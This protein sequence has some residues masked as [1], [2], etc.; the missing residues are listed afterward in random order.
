MPLTCPVD[1][2]SDAFTRCPGQRSGPPGTLLGW[3]IK[4]TI[5]LTKGSEMGDGGQGRYASVNGLRMYFEE[6]G[7]EKPDSTAPPLVLLHDAL[8]AIEGSFGR[9]VPQLAV[10]RRVIAVEQQGHGRTADLD[11]PLSYP[12]M[13]EDTAA[14]LDRIRVT[15]ADLFGLGMGAALAVQIALDRP[16]LV[17]RLV[18]GSPA[19]SPDGFHPGVLDRGTAD[20][21]QAPQEYAELA[22][23]PAD[24]AKVVAKIGRLNTAFEGWEPDTI[25]SLRAPA[26]LLAGDAD[27]V[28]LDH[29][30][31]FFRL[32]GGG[33][34]GTGDAGNDAGRDVR[35]DDAAR[36]AASQ[37]AVLPGTT[38]DTLSRRAE[39]VASM[40]EEFLDA[41]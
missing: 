24:W 37:L 2:G 33:R 12:G 18:L 35:G 26:L 36:P 5:R 38:H 32:V 20:A 27:I 15:Q 8:S 11:Q 4:L 29:V 30:V 34:P 10:N 9:L 28:R 23:N 17:R 19:Y 22:P 13:A 16:D 40:V 1:C 7:P 3:L 31:A 39:W 41:E 21:G 14:L 6:H 25:R